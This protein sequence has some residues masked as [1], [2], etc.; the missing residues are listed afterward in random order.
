[1]KNDNN[2]F[3][4]VLQDRQDQQLIENHIQEEQREIQRDF[5][6]SMSS[7]NILNILNK[8][9]ISIVRQ[10]QIYQSIKNKNAAQKLQ[11]M[12]NMLN[13]QNMQKQSNGMNIEQPKQQQ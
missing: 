1:M 2:Y 8:D 10:K 4:Q 5:N 7:Q 6:R 12:Q 11:N 3:K 13:K 9:D